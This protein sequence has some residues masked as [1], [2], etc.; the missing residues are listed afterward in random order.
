MKSNI[1]YFLIIT[2]FPSLLFSQTNYYV[3][4][5]GSNAATG[6]TIVDAWATIQYAMNNATPNSVVNILAGSYNEK[7]EVNVS[8]TLGNPITF[9]NY[10]NDVVTISGAG[11]SS[12]DAIV[13]IFDQSYIIVQ[14]LNIT[15]NEQ[16]D[17]QG[18]IV[19]GNCQ[20]IEIRNNDV[21]NINFSS[22]LGAT[23][24][25]STNSQPIIVYGSNA[26]NPVSNLIIAENTVRD[27]RTGF[28]EG[29]AVNGNVDG[30]EVSN[31]LVHDITNI[32]IDLIGHEGT[33]S[34]DDQA[35]NGLVKGNVVYNCKSPYATAGGIYVDGGKDIVIE[36]N[37]VYQNQ[38]GIEVGCEN[39]GKTTSGIKVRNNLIYGNDDAGLA[40]GG[41]D[42]PSGS[43]KVENCLFTNNTCYN[44]DVNSGD[45]GG[46]TGEINI[47]YTE[48]CILENNIFYATNTAD[49]ILYVDNVNSVNL[50]LEYNQYYMTGGVEFEYEGAIYTSLASYQI[51]TNQD[52]NAIFSDPE[53]ANTTTPD[54]HLTSISPAINAGNPSFVVAVGETDMDGASR[55]GDS[56]VDIG[57]DEFDSVLP[58]TYLAPLQ[59]VSYTDF[60]EL[61]WT[62]ESEINHK[63]YLIQRSL[64]ARNWEDIMTITGNSNN[65]TTK[66]YRV[67]DTKPALGLSYYRLKQIDYDEDFEYSNT[68]AINWEKHWQE[69]SIYPIPAKEKITIELAGPPNEERSFQIFDARGFLKMSKQNLSTQKIEIAVTGW[70]QGIYYLQITSAISRSEKWMKI[71][72]GN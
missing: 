21:S 64:D 36:N 60:I 33:A 68:V 10:N 47:S 29:L 38:W 55:V 65:S 42:F 48:N 67:R 62:T 34:G 41:F 20:Y 51:G 13:G 14:G 1:L 2:L 37:I 16:L 40:I 46:V 23:V 30:F 63:H 4:S 5:V 39:I 49:L 3:S 28:S 22:D 24:N 43:G 54:L 7:V 31:N 66:N 61:K 15:N 17:A 53:F 58:V 45:T 44:N 27:S 50:G 26:S 18:I 71:I 52:A 69:I 6:T 56:R 11:I 9:Q 72:V 8:G 25:S 59:A 70:P 12:P 19:E 32:G 35:R 57:A